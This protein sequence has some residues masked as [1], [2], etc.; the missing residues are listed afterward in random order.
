MVECA[1]KYSMRI[2]GR[3]LTLSLANDKVAMAEAVKSQLVNEGI[4]SDAL[5]FV[6]L[7][8]CFSSL[9]GFVA[10]ITNGACFNC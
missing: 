8:I 4:F 10:L 3:L 9:E 7:Y 1:F 6:D 2:V 5:T